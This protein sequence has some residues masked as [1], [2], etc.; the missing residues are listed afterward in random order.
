LISPSITPDTLYRKISR[1]KEDFNLLTSPVL[2]PENQGKSTYNIPS[3][4]IKHTSVSN[5]DFD[6]VHTISNAS[7]ISTHL[8]TNMTSP[9]FITN[10][11]SISSLSQNYRLPGSIMPVSTNTPKINYVNNSNTALNRPTFDNQ[12]NQNN[13]N[14]N[15]N[16]YSRS[17]NIYN[18]SSKKNTILAQSTSNNK[19]SNS[20]V[21]PY[22]LSRK[23]ENNNN[24]NILNY[25][26][27]MFSPLVEPMITGPLSF[28]S[29][30]PPVK[31]IPQSMLPITPSVLMHLENQQTSSISSNAINEVEEATAPQIRPT[32]PSNVNI[33]N[34]EN[35]NGIVNENTL[36]F[37]IPNIDVD[38]HLNASLNDNNHTNT[39]IASIYNNNNNNDNDDDDDKNNIDDQND[40]IYIDNE[41]EKVIEAVTPIF[42]KYLMNKSKK[43]KN[44]KDYSNN[45]NNR[46]EQ[47]HHDK[48]ENDVNNNS[49][50][51]PLL[52]DN[53][54]LDINRQ[55]F[56]MLNN[57]IL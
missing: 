24:A 45:N 13:D 22:T 44:T 54:A 42:I 26:G 35:I 23:N 31:S 29:S 25:K 47:N 27:D 7:P 46:F 56:S 1:N 55:A 28:M 34:V 36:N 3:K 41:T 43:E 37:K 57:T 32:S 48:N 5:S 17:S 15:N 33:I 39:S 20:L 2:L 14:N 53:G 19:N 50:L 38:H 11:N 40:N 52:L 6:K 49:L 10:Q 16:T 9:I 18:I 8:N 12:N 4:M 30:S 51:T 21:S